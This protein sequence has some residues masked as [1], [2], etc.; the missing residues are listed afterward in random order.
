[1]SIH[2]Q[3]E[4]AALKTNL[5]S[6]SAL[7]EESVHGAIRSLCGHD[8]RRAR[9]IVETD[10]QIDTREVY[11]EE[12]CQKLLALFQPVAHDL[13]LIIAVLKI[14]AELERIGD[15]AVKIAEHV[16]TAKLDTVE[17]PFDFGRM[18]EKAV[19]MLHKSIDALIE[20]DAAL[21]YA[22]IGM[23]D[24]VDEMHHLS[25][26]RIEQY[27]H[28]SPELF[29]VYSH[30]LGI[31]RGI[32]R[33]ADHASNIAENVIYLIEGVIVRHRTEEYRSRGKS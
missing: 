31:S 3:K 19:A 1:M 11:L 7:V 28:E 21:A 24:E 6:L 22:V 13:R 17:M 4:I 5:L 2:V 15:E 12:E 18:A 9:V 8:A 10:L 20:E 27:I 16:L 25:R 33:I 14:N 29:G 23:D 26:M 32:E 30:Y